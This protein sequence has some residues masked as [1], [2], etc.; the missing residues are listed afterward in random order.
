MREIVEADMIETRYSR[1]RAAL[2]VRHPPDRKCIGTSLYY[3]PVFRKTDVVPRSLGSRKDPPG[4]P[5]QRR[6]G[7]QRG[8]R[9][10][11][12]LRPGLGA[13]KAKTPAVQV[14]LFSLQRQNLAAARPGE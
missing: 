6:R 11:D 7:R 2:L 8:G 12:H 10:A 13:L 5:R 4:R 3:V 14:D 1:Q 9:E